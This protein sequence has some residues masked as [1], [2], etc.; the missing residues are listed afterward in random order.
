MLPNRS[1]VPI[2]ASAL[3]LAGLFA[4]FSAGCRMPAHESLIAAPKPADPSHAAVA[5]PAPASPAPPVLAA[6]PAQPLIAP[7]RVVPIATLAKVAKP[8][9]TH[10]EYRVVAIG[11]PGEASAASSI[12][13]QGVAVGSCDGPH[14]NTAFLWKNGRV[15]NLG[16]FSACAINDRGVVAGFKEIAGGRERPVLHLGARSLP[17]VLPRGSNVYV[18]AVN[19]HGLAIGN[20]LSGPDLASRAF[21]WSGRRPWPLW[22]KPGFVGSQANGISE[23]GVVAGSARLAGGKQR[24]CLWQRGRMIDLGA[25]AKGY[26][27]QAQAANDRGQVVG[28]AS[29]PT[30]TEGIAAHAFLWQHGRIADL[31]VL[32]GWPNSY[33]AAINNRGQ[34]VGTIE[35]MSAGG[36]AVTSHAFL[37]QHGRMVDLNRLISSRSGWVLEEANA[38][39]DRGEIVGSGAFMGKRRAFLLSRLAPSAVPLILVRRPSHPVPKAAANKPAL[40]LAFVPPAAPF[41]ARPAARLA[42]YQK[43]LHARHMALQEKSLRSARSAHRWQ[44]QPIPIGFQGVVVG[45]AMQPGTYQVQYGNISRNIFFGTRAEPRTGEEVRVRGVL[46]QDG[47]V[48]AAS[49]A[50]LGYR[51]VLV[52]VPPKAHAVLPSTDDSRAVALGRGAAVLRGLLDSEASMWSRNISVSAGGREIPVDVPHGIP[53]R[54]EGGPASVHDLDQGMPVKVYGYWNGKGRFHATR[55]EAL[56]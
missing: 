29:V 47:T 24:A 7:A 2:L 54:I 17:I 38:I 9:P 1:H 46:R 18:Y 49:V 41:H 37:W 25:L 52:E 11:L 28:S 42:A 8:A 53:V 31:G 44:P 21:V 4:A 10:P 35:R 26:G 14:G 30:K 5:N 16:H 34:I 6:S 15:R 55:I 56:P 33:A 48:A 43:A 23:S 40:R 12:D 13:N 3:A 20:A 19:D 32:P 27:S 36:S 50:R 45:K 39:N 51:H 22:V